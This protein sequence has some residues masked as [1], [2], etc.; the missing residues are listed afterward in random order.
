MTNVL[1]AT[2]RATLKLIDL[3]VCVVAA[4]AAGVAKLQWWFSPENLP[5]SFRVWNS[6]GVVPVP[7]HYYH[8]VFDP[9]ALPESV[10][11]RE[12]PLPGIDLQI[13]QQL[14]LLS[15]FRYVDELRK[16]PL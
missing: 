11:T 6:F 4:M 7:F 14:E 16:F 8:P 9:D 10:W 12:R 2:R 15:Q 13:G 3:C 5:R 1:A